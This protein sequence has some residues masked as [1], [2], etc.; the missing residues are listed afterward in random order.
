[1]KKHLNLAF[2]I[3]TTATIICCSSKKEE[4][5]KE[6]KQYISYYESKVIPLSKRTN[7]AWW[8]AATTGKDSAYALAQE[9]QVELTK[10]FSDSTEFAKVKHIKESGLIND[11]I[12][13]RQID[14]I[15]LSF[16]SSQADTALL[17]QLIAMQTD[18][19]KKYSNFRADVDGKKV[20]DND[21]EE[22]LSNSS[23][24]KELET[25]WLAHKQIGSLVAS[26]IKALVQKRNELAHSLGFDNYHTMSLQFS[27]Q[28][29]IEIERIFDE[30]DNLTREAFADQKKD[31]DIYL[32][33]RLNI[34]ESEL[35]PWHYQNRFFQEAPKIYNVKLDSYYEKQ[36]IEKLTKTFY[37]GIGIGIDDILANSDLYERTGKNQH[38]FCIDIDNSGDIRVLCNVKSNQQWMNT[39][40]HEFG[41][42]AYDKY[43]DTTL[44]YSLRNPAHIFTTEAIAML[45]GRFASN[46]QWI[47]DNTGISEAE[48]N[49]IA[50]DCNKSLRLEQLV[51]SRWVQV[52]YRFEKSMYANPD[53]DLNALWWQL[54][55]IYQLIKKPEGRDAPD[56][57]SKIHIATSP[58]YYHNY[59][60]GE[61]LASQLH[62]YITTNILKTE[63][64]SMVSYSNMPAVGEYLKEKVFKP[65]A[66]LEWNV[67]IER[68]TGEKLTSKYYAL[69]F[70]K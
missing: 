37:N 8:E 11:S 21:I 59:L 1:M 48:K 58:C 68:A 45:F 41:H 2:I 29:P 57:A 33:K 39:M 35:R 36:D 54:V 5:E 65:G 47:A 69:Q 67:M 52:M 13:K 25:A 23:N 6:F 42:A 63:E 55:E 31:I 26:D 12:E 51:F 64:K 34:K 28:D 18:I 3:L 38:A 24:S 60:L 70:V 15:Y 53:Q 44:P 46:P 9:L 40:L 17:N 22:I 50:D 43:I 30:L 32:A 20:S 10:F 19:E 7:L 16:L 56:W 4:M 49:T 62:Y 14:V 66:L 61:L 27:E